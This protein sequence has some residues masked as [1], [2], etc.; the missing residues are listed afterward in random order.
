M[1]PVRGCPSTRKHTLSRRVEAEVATVSPLRYVRARP[2]A[3]ETD[4]ID[5][6]IPSTVIHVEVRALA[7]VMALRAETSQKTSLPS[8]LFG[9]TR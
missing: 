3:V 6:L 1:D 9:T 2:Y 8:A 7:L 4:E 5:A